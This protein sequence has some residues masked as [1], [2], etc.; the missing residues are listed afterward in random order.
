MFL[1]R[2]NTLVFLVTQELVKKIKTINLQMLP[3]LID[4]I[5]VVIN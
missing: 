2:N 5:T 3:D 1:S 4:Y